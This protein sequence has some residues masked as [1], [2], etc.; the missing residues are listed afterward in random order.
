MAKK[1]LS[2]I[3]LAISIFL[4]LLMESRARVNAGSMGYGMGSYIIP[5]LIVEFIFSL[6]YFLSGRGILLMIQVILFATILYLATIMLS[7]ESMLHAF[8]P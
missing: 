6:A 3:L 7:G 1:V 2:C 4:V 8:V 5:M